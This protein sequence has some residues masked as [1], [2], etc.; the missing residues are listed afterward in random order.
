MTNLCLNFLSLSCIE[1][2]KT[3]ISKHHSR[4]KAIQLLNQ[5]QFYQKRNLFLNEKGFQREKMRQAIHQKKE[6]S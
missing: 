3:K 6:V 1:V 4:M 2:N 5:V